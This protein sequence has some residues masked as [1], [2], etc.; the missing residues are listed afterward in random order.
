[1]SKILITALIAC[2]LGFGIGRATKAKDLVEITKLIPPQMANIECNE[3][4][5]LSISS[6]YYRGV[7]SGRKGSAALYINDYLIIDL[8]R[9]FGCE[10]LA[11]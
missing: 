10:D 9:I 5:S 1:M 6:L 8:P 7:E 4:G 3:Y 11:P 2:S